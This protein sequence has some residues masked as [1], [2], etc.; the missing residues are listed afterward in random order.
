MKDEEIGAAKVPTWTLGDRMRKSLDEAGLG[1]SEIADELGVTRGAVG[2]WIHGRVEPRH[3]TLIAWALRTGV[4]L[5][6]L[7]TG[8]EAGEVVESTGGEG[9]EATEPDPAPPVESM[10]RV[11]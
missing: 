3:P 10:A 5:H 2:K 11:G 9:D 8:R 4:S 7:E 1:V 6:W